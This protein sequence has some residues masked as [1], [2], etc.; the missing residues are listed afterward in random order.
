VFIKVGTVLT[1][2]VI[3]TLYLLRHP[4]VAAAN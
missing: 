2:V 4:Q 3:A 1:F